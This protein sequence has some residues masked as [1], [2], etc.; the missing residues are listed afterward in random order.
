MPRPIPL[1]I[2]LLPLL[3]LAVPALRAQDLPQ[4]QAGDAATT[5]GG[6][7]RSV[8]IRTVNNLQLDVWIDGRRVGFTPLRTRLAPGTYLLTAG[9]EGVEPVISLVEVPVELPS[10]DVTQTTL[11]DDRILIPERFPIVFAHMARSFQQHPDNPHFILLAMLLTQDREDFE[12]LLEMLPPNLRNDPMV[13][14]AQAAW[15]AEE[16]NIEGGLETLREATELEPGF[17]ALWRA[18]TRLALR[19]GDVDRA[20]A[21]SGQAVAMEST[22]PQNYHTRARV[23][24][25]MENERGARYDRER[26]RELE[27]EIDRRFERLQLQ[28]MQVQ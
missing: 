15:Q 6:P 9:T 27:A 13:A 11:I 21:H 28:R 26:A 1:L 3:C 2:L 14:L 4:V 10:G 25:A 5:P 23:Y 24:D 12:G 17:A 16:G 18:K 20:F 8:A 7:I 19:L 22:N